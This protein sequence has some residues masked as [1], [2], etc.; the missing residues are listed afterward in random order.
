M[1]CALAA[2]MLFHGATPANAQ[3]GH[4][5]GQ[6][7]FRDL[8]YKQEL[9]LLTG[10]HAGSEGRAGIAPAGGPLLG[11]RYEI[12]IGG[13][14]TFTA[15][16]GRVWSERTVIDPTKPDSTRSLGKRDWPIYL[17]DVGISINLTGQKSFWQLVPVL[18]GGIGVATDFSKGGDPGGY[19]F[20]TPFAFNFGGGVRWVG[21]N[22][23]QLRLDIADYL[24]QLE[25]PDSYFVPP[26]GQTEGAVLAQSASKNEYTHNAV[27]TLGVSYLFSR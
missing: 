2:V 9:S 3:V 16:L 6:S 21:S 17:S 15:R 22:R 13:P 11:V 24:Y 10:F 20:G 8:A 7:P 14:A 25:Y 4:L 27:I 18:N 26:V 23:L 19:S 12:R 5:P 1:H